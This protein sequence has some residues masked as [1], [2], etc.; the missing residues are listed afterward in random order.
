MMEAAGMRSPSPGRTPLVQ[1]QR[2]ILCALAL[3]PWQFAWE[4]QGNI[5]R[6]WGW[7]QDGLQGWTQG[8]AGAAVHL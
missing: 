6:G 7:E 4:H 3:F 5:P 8:R 1:A 2:Q